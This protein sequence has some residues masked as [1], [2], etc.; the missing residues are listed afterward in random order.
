MLL[1]ETDAYGG[2]IVAE[3]L[4]AAIRDIP[5]PIE[6]RRVDAATGLLVDRIPISVSIG[7][8]VYPGARRDRTAGAGR[9]RRRAVR[10]QER[11]PGHV[12]AGRGG[13]A[14]RT[15]RAIRSRR[16]PRP[17]GRSRRG[18]VVADS[19]AACPGTIRAEGAVTPQMT[20]NAHASGRRAVK[21]VIPAAGLATRFLPATK[22]VPKELLPV[23]DRP[24]LQYIV[25]EAAAAGI[26]RRPADHRSR[27]DQHGRP[28]RPPALPRVAAG[29]E[30]RPGA[31]GRGPPHQRTGRDLHLP[32]GRAARARSRGRLRRVARRRQR[33]SRCCSATSSSTRTSPLLPAMLDLQA[34]TGGIVLAFIEVDPEETIAVRHRVGATE[35]M[36][37]W[38]TTDVVEVTGLVE[39]PAAG[40]GAEQ[41]GGGRPLRPARRDLRRDP[42]DQAGQRRRDPADRRDGAAAG[43]GHPGARHRLPRAP[44]RHR[45][46]AGLPAGRRAAR[47]QAR[48]PRAAEFRAVADRVRRARR[49]EG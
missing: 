25:E 18:R 47:G 15:G 21:A 29:G 32:A 36:P 30:G 4:G 12:P 5:V 3:R 40:E 7:V 43:R 26:T 38:A 9:G 41:P 49:I 2:A 1:P 42:A 39:K 20:T 48:R 10:G 14:G 22:A 16:T 11:G 37:T 28:L 17:A 6:T 35:P 45:H 8:A 44:L 33:R 19:L 13:F 46:A 23:V 31:A 24:V 34:R 27:Q